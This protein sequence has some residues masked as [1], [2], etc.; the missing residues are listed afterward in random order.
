MKTINIQ[1]RRSEQNPFEVC[2]GNGNR[3]TFKS[4]RNARQFMA[5]TNRFLT[6]ALTTLNQTY[7]DSFREYRLIWFV[8]ANANKGT[9]TN[10]WA[11]E[12]KIKDNL[13]ACETIFT[14]FGGSWGSSDDPYFAFIDLRKIASFMLE[15]NN[16]MLEFHKKRNNT[17]GYYVCLTL[18]DRC[19]AVVSKLLAYPERQPEK[20]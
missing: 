13:D 18:S 2:M 5:E 19:N 17:A 11:T 6:K 15:A 7:I 14:K 8:T 10:Y 1:K 4:K 12:R 20:D 16:T 9:K 3:L